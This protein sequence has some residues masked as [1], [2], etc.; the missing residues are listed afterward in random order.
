MSKRIGFKRSFILL[1]CLVLAAS[2][3]LGGAELERENAGASI[4]INE[5]CSSNK[6]SLVDENVG[7]PD[8]IELYNSSESEINLAGYALSDNYRSLHKFVFD[9]SRPRLMNT[10]IFG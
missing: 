1:V 9:F 6:R 7:S 4:I 2:P 3:L 10:D 5:I 8:W